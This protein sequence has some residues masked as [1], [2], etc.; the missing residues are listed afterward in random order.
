MTKNSKIVIGVATAAAAGTVIG[1]LFATEKGSHL[2]DK[3]REAANNF[4]SDL[5]ETIQR[6]RQ[7]HRNSYSEIEDSAMKLKSKAV[8]KIADLKDRVKE[9][10]QETTDT[11]LL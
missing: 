2:R 5:L 10:I 11:V 3:V 4:A 9:G 8:A 6:G 1:M 7:Q